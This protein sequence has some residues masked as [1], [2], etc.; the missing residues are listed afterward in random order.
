MRKILLSTIALSTL[1]LA[2]TAA[3]PAPVKKSENTVFDRIH[4]KGDLRLRYESIERDDEKN[5]YRNRYRLRIGANVNL[6]DKLDFEVG[7]RSGFANP[8]SGNQTFEDDQPLKD[9]F[10]R[11]LRFNIL[12]LAYKADNAKYKFG[13]QPYMMYRPIKSQ[14]VWD[15]D[16]SMHGVNYQYKDN[17]KV[18]TL[19]V[20]QP[21]LEEASVARDDVNLLIA[22]YVHKTKVEAGKLNLGAGAY[23]YDGFKGNSTFFGSGKGNNLDANGFYTNDYHIA[24]GFA[25]FQIKDVFGK[26]LTL[27]AGVAYNFGA[28]DNNFGYD[29]AAQLGKAKRIGDWQVKYSYTEL[30]E[31]AVL[32]AYSD[33]DN[34]GGGTAAR[35]HAVRAK[36]KAGKNLFLAG[37]FFFNELYASTSKNATAVESD[38]DRVQLDMI[39]KF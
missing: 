24:E 8:T 16:V 17:T 4:A 32:G 1:V 23:I 20:N 34:F 29:V 27:A 14:L 13:R 19:G 26:P 31:D 2:E 5:K 6:T 25:D 9:Y 21:T 28:D 11:S 38:Y 36:Y 15:N 12:G 37:N 10:W 18:V 22:Q 39:Y 7:M 33:S 3:T 30:Q 35:G